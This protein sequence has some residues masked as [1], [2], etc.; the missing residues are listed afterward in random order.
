MSKI[1]VENKILNLK[2]IRQTL[3]IKQSM[4]DFIQLINQ[5]AVQYIFQIGGLVY[6]YFLNYLKTYIQIFGF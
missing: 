3:L 6:Y 4:F 5:T 2:Y 1:S